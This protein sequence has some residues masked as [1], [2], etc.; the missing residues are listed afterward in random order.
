MVFPL[1]LKLIAIRVLVLHC[2][3]SEDS[4]DKQ[5]A[6]AAAFPEVDKARPAL[7]SRSACNQSSRW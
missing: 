3:R 6:Q 7:I 5:R 4:I 2:S 1:T